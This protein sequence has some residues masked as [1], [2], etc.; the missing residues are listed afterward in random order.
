[1]ERKPIVEVR[2]LVAGYGDYLVLDRVSMD[3]YEGEIIAVIGGSGCGK[4]TLLKNMVGLLR[5]V[6]G[7]IRYWGREI[8]AMDEEEL[9]ELLRKLGIAFQSGALFNSMTVGENIS[10]PMEEY[11][12]MDQEL[13]EILVG[14]KLDLVGLSG[15]GDLMPDELSGGMKKRVGFARAIAMDP[16]IVFFDEPSTS[17]DPII[18]AGLDKLILEMRRLLGITVFVVTHDLGS[19]R[20][21]ADR[22][23]MLDRGRVI[24]TGTVSDVEKTG[25]ARVRQFF[26]RQPDKTIEARGVATV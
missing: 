19:I 6:S 22:I 15:T 18:A 16:R 8:T 20:L 11:G 1:M 23:V 25:V 21:I 7:S 5:P 3:V 12:D 9:A 26:D 2:D 17:L 24:F 10:L 4:S 13:R 14:I